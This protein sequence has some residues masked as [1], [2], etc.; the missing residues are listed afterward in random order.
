MEMRRSKGIDFLDDKALAKM[1]ILYILHKF[2]DGVGSQ[3]L[4]DRN[5]NL[6]W[7]LA[8]DKVDPL[9]CTLSTM[10]EIVIMH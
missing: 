4:I 6:S 3:G 9:I 10:R 1:V 2:F 8:I 7:M 5:V